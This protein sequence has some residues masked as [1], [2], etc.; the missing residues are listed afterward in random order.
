MRYKLYIN[1]SPAPIV[2]V[3]QLGQLHYEIVTHLDRG[4]YVSVQDR[5]RNKEIDKEE[6]VRILGL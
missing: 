1:G 3:Q 6:L 4:D 5:L 2:P